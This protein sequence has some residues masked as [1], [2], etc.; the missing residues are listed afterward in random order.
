MR[1]ALTLA[2]LG[3]DRWREIECLV[4]MAKIAVECRQTA[5][6]DSFCY[7]IDVVADRIGDAPR[8]SPTR[9]G[10]WR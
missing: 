7:E 8:L 6:I 5:G 4:W 1:R 10:P 3:E 2:R 9:C